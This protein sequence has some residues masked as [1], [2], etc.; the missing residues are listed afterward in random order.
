M[1][2]SP[3]KLGFY[4][5]LVGEY[6]QRPGNYYVVSHRQGRT[7]EAGFHRL[8]GP[9]PTHKEADAQVQSVREYA[10]RSGG[11]EA[12]WQHYITAR[13]E[14]EY[15]PKSA[16][17]SDPRKWGEFYDLTEPEVAVL[18]I[19]SARK[20]CKLS[21]LYMAEPVLR[22]WIERAAE[23]LKTFKE[24]DDTFV[25]GLFSRSYVT[26]TGKLTDKGRRALAERSS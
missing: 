6:D 15:A 21:D 24:I 19:H 13:C 9:F 17:G 10:E 23:G 22:S 3:D 4:S 18:R 8:A 14:P 5:T 25:S 20:G 1:S 26:R 7:P 2:V 11:Q 12:F 16:L